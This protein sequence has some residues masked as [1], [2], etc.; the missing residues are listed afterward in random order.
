MSNFKK[1]LKRIPILKQVLKCREKILDSLPVKRFR[2]NGYMINELIYTLLN[3]KFSYFLLCGNLLGIIREN[4]F[5]DY[6]SDFDYGILIDSEDMWN[7]LKN[8]LLKNGFKIHHFIKYNDSICEF[9]FFYKK[10]NI[11][12]FKINVNGGKAYLSSFYKSPNIEYVN[13]ELSVMKVEFDYIP[14]VEVKIVNNSHMVIP[15]FYESFL[16]SNYGNDWMVPQRNVYT[17]SKIG[18]RI[19]YDNERA[20][21]YKK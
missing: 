21:S 10:I 15:N 16:C 5:L 4:K 19:H 9:S 18:N 1:I 12:F 11:D 14:G 13:N 3:E 2:K 6:E 20:F 7:Q 17:T 8:L